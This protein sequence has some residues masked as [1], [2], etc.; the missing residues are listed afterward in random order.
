[1]SVGVGPF[2]HIGFGWYPGRVSWIYRGGYIGWIP[3]APYESYYCRR[4][5]GPRSVVVNNIHLIN[6]REHRHR[7]HAVVVKQ[8]HFYGVDNYHKFRLT[9]IRGSSIVNSYRGVAVINSRVIRD[10]KKVK[11]RFN[12]R[13]VEVK[14]KPHQSVTKRIQRRSPDR[15]RFIKEPG[16]GIQARAAKITPGKRVT[17]ASIKKSGAKG[18]I[19]SAGKIKKPE[20]IRLK[21]GL[22]KAPGSMDNKVRSKG[23]GKPA[24]KIAPGRKAKG[25]T[26]GTKMKGYTPG[27]KAQRSTPGTTPG[28]SVRRSTPGPKVHGYTPGRKMKGYTPGTS[29]QRSLPGTTPGTSVRRS[30]PSPQVRSFTPKT[31]GRG[32]T[33]Q[34]RVPRSTTRSGFRMKGL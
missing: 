23:V 26:P 5:W 13:N 19:I 8:K 1:V 14:R 34:P 25:Y 11:G 2:F 32:F 12:F 15:R 4:Y 3:L 27:K 30:T 22:R 7:N 18:K 31:R 6:E 21:E 17:Q 33:S 10:F 20:K 9:N 24:T 29:V 28:T 16:R